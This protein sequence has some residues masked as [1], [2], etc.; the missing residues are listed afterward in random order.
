MVVEKNSTSPVL[1]NEGENTIEVAE[2]FC[3]VL[4]DTGTGIIIS[5]QAL[6]SLINPST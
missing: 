2:L 6:L 5:H 4:S 3:T 1:H